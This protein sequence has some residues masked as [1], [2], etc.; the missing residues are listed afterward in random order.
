MASTALTQQIC[1]RLILRARSSA[2][3][4]AFSRCH[5]STFSFFSRNHD[6]VD[7]PKTFLPEQL[8]SQTRPIPINPKAMR[9][10]P[11]YDQ[12]APLLSA[13]QSKD[14]DTAWM[15]YSV[16]S[17]AGQLSSLL[18]IHHSLLLK[19]IRPADPK[20]FTT[21]E[22]QKLTKRFEQVWAG[23]LSC[24]IQPDMNNYT[25]RLEFF[26]AT[27]QYATVDQTWREMSAE[28]AGGR[29]SGGPP[30]LPTLFT[31][32]LIL[33]SC[34]PRKN[35]D[36]A[37]DVIQSMKRAGVQPDTTS[38]DYVLQV[39]TAMKNWSAIEAAF[40]SAFVTTQDSDT[41]GQPSALS[42][43][44]AYRQQG[45]TSELMAIPLGQ[46]P[47]TLHGGTLNTNPAN[48]SRNKSTQKSVTK[49]YPSIQNIHTL[50]GYYAY[51][52][53]IDALRAMFESHVR[54]F[55]VV[56]TTRTYNE[57]IKFAFLSRRDG[58]AID[59]FKEL[60]QI[61]QNLDKIQEISDT[62]SSSSMT[63]PVKTLGSKAPCFGPDF[64]TFQIMV[65]SELMGARGRWGRAWRWMQIM[66]D[67]YGLLPS[68]K[69]FMRTLKAMRRRGADDSTIQ[70]LETNWVSVR[71]RDEPA[72]GS[73][74]LA[75]AA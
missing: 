22:V 29:A 61:G 46:K 44:K 13:I 36:L 35:I 5:Y 65:N 66:Q 52:Q 54:L 64:N 30:L 59:L 24:N 9:T 39:H 75:R 62:S 50:F 18:P 33:K 58:D 56:P 43:Q 47:R 28:M 60:V 11:S 69:M 68:D 27:R 4:G 2:T 67:N 74:Y 17:R 26:V 25:T 1:T 20:R 3:A 31:Y 6:S 32:N 37:S 63:N 51:T 38:W 21:L 12:A 14:Q 73:R 7:L 55:G 19:S 23:M 71:K 15:I 16:L 45:S 72:D 53:D 40:R 57:M 34:V 49:L 70:A 42:L 48:S 41:T 10:S 8:H